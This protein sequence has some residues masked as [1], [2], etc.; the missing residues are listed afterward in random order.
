M[1][2]FLGLPIDVRHVTLSSGTIAAAIYTLGFGIFSEPAAYMAL[3][4]VV[5]TGLLNLSISF[6]ISLRVAES[7]NALSEKN[8][9]PNYSKNLL[10]WYF[11]KKLHLQ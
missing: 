4:G 3:L 10:I 1:G 6:V 11:R 9:D 8:L 7:S 5:V 2:E